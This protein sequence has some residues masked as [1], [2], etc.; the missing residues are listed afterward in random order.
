MNLD[1]KQ[2]IELI[3]I[4]GIVGSLIF[5][6]LQLKFDSQVAISEQF[7]Y[8]AESA[9]SDLRT[10]LESEAVLEFRAQSWNQGERWP[11]WSD[12]YEDIVENRNLSG[13]NVSNTPKAKM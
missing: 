11:W 6:G 3:G 8:R 7:N 2:L 5:V 9:K 10:A 12:E 4:V 1:N 13:K